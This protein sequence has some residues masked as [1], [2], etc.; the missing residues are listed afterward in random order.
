LA[1]F[2][3]AALILTL[4][5]CDSEAMLAA[6]SS[7]RDTALRILQ[8]DSRML[9]FADV[10]NQL[11]TSRRMLG[12]NEEFEA[13][14]DEVMARVEKMTGVRME[15]DLH[16]VYVGLSD[17]GDDP[18]GGVVA[19]VDF[20]QDA[21]S[22]QAA[23][24]EGVVRLDTNWPVDAYTVEGRD[25]GA[26]VAF[27]EGSL[28]LF[29]S[30]ARVLTGML[31]RAYGE[32]SAVTM[33]PLLATVADRNTWFVARD[34]G[35]LMNELPASGGSPEMAMIRPL[36]AGIQD[37]AFGMDQD[38]ERMS[39]EFLIRPNDNVTVDD[40]ESLLSGVRAMLRLQFRDFDVA[41]DMID[42][43]DIDAEDEW[44]SLSMDVNREEMERLEEELREEMR[45]RFD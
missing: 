10:E 9:A 22:R 28:I 27:A 32:S 4:T 11:A 3:C 41:S 13:M 8:V 31:D 29:A 20:D 26:S 36:L 34:A 37:V 18:R 6:D 2:A 33:D 24:T 44:V 42:R 5:G 17:F 19:F 43:I 25:R 35:R 45:A 30:D 1:F 38:G 21:L 39:S 16:S 12:D 7:D 23:D 14:M 40:Y 15:E